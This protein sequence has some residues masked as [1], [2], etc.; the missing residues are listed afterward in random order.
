MSPVR[1]ATP[2]FRHFA[3]SVSTAL[4]FLIA[5]FPSVAQTARPP[6]AKP[7]TTRT[8]PVGFPQDAGP[9]DATSSI[10]WW[11]FNA[12]LTTEKGKKFAVVG[13]FFRVG[14][15]NSKKGHYLIYSLAD[16]SAN[17]RRAYSILDPQNVAYL[18]TVTILQTQLNPTDPRPFQLLAYLEKD[19]LPA[20]HQK[21]ISNAVV[22]TK[23]RFTMALGNNVLSQE[24][25][26]GRTWH[27]ALN[28]GEDWT[29]DL[30]MEQPAL[31]AM[32]P[33]GNGKTGVKRPD[34][35]YYLTL[36]RMD[37][38]GTLEQDG[39]VEGVTG[40]GWLDRQWGSPEMVTNYS[41]DWFGIR[42]DDGND[43]LLMRVREAA[44][45]K[46]V[47][48][49][50]TLLTKEGVQTVEKPTVY[51]PTGTWIDPATNIT[52]PA[53]FEVTL[54]TSGYTLTM[55]PV[56]PEQT[57]PV[58]GVGDAIWEGVVEVRGTNKSGG[59]VTGQG[60]MELH[61]YRPKPRKAAV[62]G[63]EGTPGGTR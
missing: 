33:G 51:K 29:L 7:P 26:D 28:G 59:A 3:A 48:Q 40:I 4:F 58:L 10:E 34:D 30:E 14:L 49:F 9:H 54:P 17:T 53:G 44:S 60:Y 11:Y 6:V 41:W 20:P 13:S 18:R 55:T 24:S 21:L 36:S 5:A 25:A 47:Q 56:F 52:F 23:P 16:L 46:T 32:L 35:M 63:G 8:T 57:I 15:P 12:F 22:R 42:L 19:R 27:V 37:V 38:K 1:F 2:L 31:R 62:G 39:E 43:L 45:G 50:A 61:G